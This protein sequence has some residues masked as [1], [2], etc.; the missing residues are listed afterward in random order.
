MKNRGNAA[1]LFS[2]LQQDQD[3]Q[4]R[5]QALDDPERFIDLAKQQ[6]YQL[7][8][9]QIEDQIVALTAEAVAAIWN[10]GIGAR[11]HLIRR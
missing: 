1:H 9:H 10:P 8:I 7:S 5:Q 4:L 6:G 11:R 3:R 2:T